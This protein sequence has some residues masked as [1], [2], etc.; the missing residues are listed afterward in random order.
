VSTLNFTSGS[1]LANAAIVPAGTG[2]GINLFVNF[3]TDL[4]I[5]INGYY[6]GTGLVTTLNTLSGDIT[7]AG[8]T[9]VT[10]TPSGN[11][12]TVA[13]PATL[14]GVTAGTGIAVSGGAPSPTVLIPPSGILAD[15]IASG[16]VA[17][18]VNN[19]KDG[20]TIS[21]T[22]GTTVS[23]VGST[24]TVASPPMSGLALN[25]YS[26]RTFGS[27]V[28]NN[29]GCLD[30]DTSSYSQ[31]RLDLPLPTGAVITGVNVRIVDVSPASSLNVQL[32]SVSFPAG[33]GVSFGDGV[34]SGVLTSTDSVGSN[35][36]LPGLMTS[37]PASATFSYYIFA[38]APAHS[39]TLSFCGSSVTFTVN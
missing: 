27:V 26:A 21:G 39:G 3:S 10:I 1:V 16:Q 5:D 22:G 19:I 23:T 15:R 33:T 8:G 24:I 38:E 11:T 4:I 28:T 6:A 35:V 37:S 2:G 30:F 20:I 14:T 12:L 31:I 32:R 36:P 17:K 18:S 29:W 13:S 7:L 34:A 9:N 25:A